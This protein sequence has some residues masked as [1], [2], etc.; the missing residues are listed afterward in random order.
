M[1]DQAREDDAG[2]SAAWQRARA[3]HRAARAESH[4]R[5]TAALAAKEQA[6]QRRCASMQTKHVM[7]LPFIT[8][9]PQCCMLYVLQASGRTRAIAGLRALLGMSSA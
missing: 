9:P 7:R 5:V 3:E 1:P 4:A 6:E 8:L 2:Y